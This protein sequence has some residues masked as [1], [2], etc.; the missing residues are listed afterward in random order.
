MNGGGR[1]YLIENKKWKEK[2]KI[3]G[4]IFFRACVKFL[5]FVLSFAYRLPQ[6]ELVTFRISYWMRGAVHV[7]LPG[8]RG[9]LL[10][11]IG[12]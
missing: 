6:E 7:V 12:N 4:C 8:L 11:G 5:V 9:F 10:V 2:D 3:I 1:E